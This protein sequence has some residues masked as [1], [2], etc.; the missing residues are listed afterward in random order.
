MINQSPSTSGRPQVLENPRVFSGANEN[1]RLRDI[2]TQNPGD[3]RI[4]NFDVGTREI[5]PRRPRL[6]LVGWQ[7]R[8]HSN[9][10]GTGRCDFRGIVR[11]SPSCAPQLS[12]PRPPVLSSDGGALSHTHPGTWQPEGRMRRRAPRTLSAKHYRRPSLDSP[13]GGPASMLR[14]HLL[15]IGGDNLSREH[16]RCARYWAP[17]TPPPTPT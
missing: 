15:K 3:V 9:R 11:L 10:I 12:P 14:S 5:R 6:P 13:S 2:R 7:P 17:M 4:T 1:L 8:L 16:T